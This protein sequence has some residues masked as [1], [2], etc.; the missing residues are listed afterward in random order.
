M[1]STR[2]IV[3]VAGQQAQLLDEPTPGF[4][5]QAVTTLLDVI[6]LQGE[7]VGPQARRDRT[8][9]LVADLGTKVLL[10]GGE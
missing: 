9:K 3:E 6:R 7:G 8:L 2:R 10:G 1:T 4:R 5:A